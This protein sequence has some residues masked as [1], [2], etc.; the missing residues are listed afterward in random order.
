MFSL[1]K[2]FFVTLLLLTGLILS[3]CFTKTSSIKKMEGFTD[4]V[5]HSDKYGFSLSFPENWLEN[6]SVKEEE[7][8]KISVLSFV[9]NQLPGQEY[10]IFRLYVYPFDVWQNYKNSKDLILNEQVFAYTNEYVFVLV[11]TLD[12][13]YSSPQMEHFGALNREVGKVLESFKIDSGKEFKIDKFKIYFNNTKENPE[14]LDCR[15]VYFVTRPVSGTLSYEEQSLRSLFAGPTDQE[16]ES[17]YQSFFSST[18][19]KIL[20]SI[21][22]VENVALVNLKDVRT[23]I[24]NANSSCGS[25]QFLAEIEKTLKEFP[26]IYQVYMAIDEEPQ[27]IY[28]WLQLGCSENNFYCDKTPFKPVKTEVDGANIETPVVPNA[29]TTAQ[30]EIV[31]TTTATSTDNSKV[32]TQKSKSQP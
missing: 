25:A 12:N 14:M 30:E 28:D 3:G 8:N 27:R 15:L 4:K 7:Q 24:P 21:R 31:A 11:R 20:R 16:K 1:K 29:T 26:H 2:I 5:Y 23:L 22:V 6:F 18:T 9:Y 10:P 19:A 13:P 17:G 32:K